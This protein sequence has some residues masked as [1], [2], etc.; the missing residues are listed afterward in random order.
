MTLRAVSL[1]VMAVVA[2]VAFG[3]GAKIE[4]GAPADGGKTATD[5][6]D[7]A[8]GDALNNDPALGTGDD[9]ASNPEV[10]ATGGDGGPSEPVGT[11]AS[12]HDGGIVDD[13]GVSGTKTYGASEVANGTCAPVV[14][15]PSACGSAASLDG[16]CTSGTKPVAHVLQQDLVGGVTGMHYQCLDAKGVVLGDINVAG[17]CASVGDWY[18][19]AYQSCALNHQALGSFRTAGT[20]CS[21]PVTTCSIVVT[22]CPA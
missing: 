9:A 10:K 2:T 6:A 8:V 4:P 21:L 15:N 1:A 20:T 12:I 5:I 22:C 19:Q 18:A 16:I 11:D 7:V 17:S 13:G 14:G 3:C